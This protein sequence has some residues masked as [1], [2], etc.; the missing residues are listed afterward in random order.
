MIP[1]FAITPSPAGLA[2]AAAAVALGAPWFSDGLHALRLRGRLAR[3]RL[4]P[5]SPSADGFTHARGVVTLDSPLFTP[6]GGQPCA[7]FRLQVSGE[8][9]AVRRALEVRR[10]FRL[11]DGEVAA[12]VPGSAGH[13][14][15]QV[16]GT[17]RVAAGEPLTENLEALLEG[18]P[19][20]VWLRR[21]GATL[22]LEERALLAG[23]EC[24]VVGV[25]RAV[26]AR[27]TFVEEELARTGTD[28]AAVRG[29]QTVLRAMARGESSRSPSEPEVAFD[30]NEPIDFLRVSDRAPSPAELR[31]PAARVA[32]LVFGPLLSLAGILYLAAVADLLREHGRL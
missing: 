11:M 18:L 21:A 8:G 31:I 27:I 14:E 20:A 6:L 3:L 16:T 30:A 10:G 22:V 29:E 25:A 19:E 23:S 32:G 12:R 15:L 5:L 17:R 1:G 9:T 13:W 4:D 24:H 26:P 7:G 28:D 2:L